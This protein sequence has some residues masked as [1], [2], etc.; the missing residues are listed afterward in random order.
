[1]STGTFDLWIKGRTGKLLKSWMVDFALQRCNASGEWL[2][3]FYPEVIPQL[4]ER[5]AKPAIARDITNYS[6]LTDQ[7]TNTLEL[8]F[9]GFK[10]DENTASATYGK[11]IAYSETRSITFVAPAS[12]PQQIACQIKSAMSD[13]AH[14]SVVDGQILIETIDRGPDTKLSFGASNNCNLKFCFADGMGW[15]VHWRNY[16]GAKRIN[17]WPGSGKTINHFEVDVPPGEYLMWCRCCHEGNEE[18]NQRYTLIKCG[19][20]TCENLILSTIDVCGKNDWFPMADHVVNG[21]L[22]QLEADKIAFL[23]GMKYVANIEKAS[24]QANLQLRLI[25]AA[26]SPE[27]GLETRINAILA[28]VDQLPEYC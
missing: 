26:L 3:D 27:T 28:I 8:V 13:M 6:S 18:T 17:I 14:I 23:K 1:M 10:T 25:D 21:G 7:A 5:Y 12:T 19:D 24:M 20:H 15:R 4:K 11:G 9:D 2:V 16:V 22:I